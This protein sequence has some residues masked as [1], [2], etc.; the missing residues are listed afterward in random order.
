MNDINSLSHSKWR[1]K[2]HI[3][4]A[5]KYR[6]QAIYGKIKR[7]I[8][9]ILRKL[10]ENKGV[11]IIEAELCKDHVHMLVSIPPSESVAQF[12]GYLKGKS[13]LMIFDRHANLK[14]KYGSRHF[15]CRGYYVDTVGKNTEKIA[16]YIRNQL[17]ED[18]M[19]DQVSLKEYIDPFT[20]S[21]NTKA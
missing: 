9:V 16:E 6:R 3:V 5:P 4:F 10:C 8:G 12:I 13:S 1:C 2:Y 17:Q 15:W 7:D 11:E 20:G 18:I 21:K 19:N 14:Y